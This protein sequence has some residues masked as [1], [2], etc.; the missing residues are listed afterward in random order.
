[1]IISVKILHTY[2]LF[3]G[4]LE[5]LKLTL[6]KL[7]IIEQISEVDICSYR[8]DLKPQHLKTFQ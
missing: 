5:E 4:F 1:M 8:G 2:I 6:K 7:E 3:R